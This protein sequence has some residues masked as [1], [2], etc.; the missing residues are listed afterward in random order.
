MRGLRQ[1]PTLHSTAGAQATA[2][3][4]CRVPCRQLQRPA[5]AAHNSA[6]AGVS[7]LPLHPAPCAAAGC[8]RGQLLLVRASLDP[9][10]I[11]ETKLGPN[12]A[13]G[14][15]DVK[16]GLTWRP[17]TVIRNECVCSSCVCLH[18]G[19][20]PRA[21]QHACARARGGVHVAQA[22]HRP[23]VHSTAATHSACR[24]TRAPER[25]TPARACLLVGASTLRAATACCT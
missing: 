7:P 23:R 10:D 15:K 5:G 8:S 17:A 13:A 21:H 4:P 20:R 16:D 9:D 25:R 6:V 2:P 12:V 14:I 11:H 3:A 19:V 1:P 24:H 18:A 22:A